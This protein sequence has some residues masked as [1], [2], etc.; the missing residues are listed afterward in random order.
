MAEHLLKKLGAEAGVKDLTVTSAGIAP[1]LTLALPAEAV[2]ALAA[3]GVNVDDHR[4]K[5][6]DARMVKK[7][8]VIIAMEPAHRAFIMTRYPGAAGKVHLITTLAGLK[9]DGVKDPFGGTDEDYR[10]ALSEIKTALTSI[11]KNW[12]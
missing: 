8:D 7:A 12:K 1:A 3:E 5:A 2:R 9:G 11:V 4:P 10:R 6:V